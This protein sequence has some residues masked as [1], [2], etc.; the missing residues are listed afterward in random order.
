MEENRLW[1]RIGESI[2]KENYLDI[3]LAS[4]Y[5]PQIMYLLQR[6]NVC[7]QYLALVVTPLTK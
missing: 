6:S 2:D 3:H 1:K 4:K 5:N 7:L